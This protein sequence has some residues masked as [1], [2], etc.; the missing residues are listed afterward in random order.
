MEF[1]VDVYVYIYVYIKLMFTQ[2]KTFWLYFNLIFI[3]ILPQKTAFKSKPTQME[4]PNNPTTPV[5]PTQSE[6]T[7]VASNEVVQSEVVASESNVSVE[8]TSPLDETHYV[9]ANSTR[10]A[11]RFILTN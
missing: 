4:Q 7:E 11:T 9:D 10:F 6:D 1:L 2:S 3:T 8:N 5:E